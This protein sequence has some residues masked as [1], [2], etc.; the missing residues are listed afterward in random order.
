MYAIRSYYEH[1]LWVGTKHGLNRYN[2]STDCFTSYYFDGADSLAYGQNI[3]SDLFEDQHQ[4]LWVVTAKSILRFNRQSNTFQS[5]VEWIDS[6]SEFEY[7]SM[8][9]D[10]RITSYNVCYT[11]LLR[12]RCG[13]TTG[14]G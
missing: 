2:R 10:A 3:I 6:D 9:Q 11:K 7:C 5:V 13:L 12:L 4:Q 1:T 14:K 8:A